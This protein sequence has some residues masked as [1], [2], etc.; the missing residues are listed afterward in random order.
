LGK[1]AHEINFVF[2]PKHCSGNHGEIFHE[3]SAFIY[4]SVRQ[5]SNLKHEETTG[6]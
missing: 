4:V 2:L 1:W 6:I 3:G 5:T